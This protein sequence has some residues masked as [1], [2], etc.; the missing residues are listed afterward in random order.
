[1]QILRYLN[2]K[3]VVHND[4]KPANIFL[5][6]QDVF[7]SGK[8]ILKQIDHRHSHFLL[9][10]SDFDR[11]LLEGYALFQREKARNAK[12]R[13]LL[14]CSHF[15]NENVWT[16]FE[17]VC[18]HEILSEREIPDYDR[19][20][21]ETTKAIARL[22]LINNTGIL[23]NVFEFCMN[24]VAVKMCFWNNRPKMISFDCASM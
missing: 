19:I 17:L 22:S 5:R 9:D 12:T 13:K 10:S 6:G 7:M 21:N 4:I 16:V 24:S 3:N 1:M 15:E 20:I 11:D 23:F 14:E 18:V 2:F 8:L